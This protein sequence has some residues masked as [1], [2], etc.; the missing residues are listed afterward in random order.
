[1]DLLYLFAQVFAVTMG[2]CL[3]VIIVFGG[4]LFALRSGQDSAE[5]KDGK[6]VVDWKGEE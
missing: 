3:G 5:K 6:H 2:I 4:L 1:M